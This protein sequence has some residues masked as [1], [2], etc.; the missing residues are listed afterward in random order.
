M[1]LA[2]AAGIGAHDGDRLGNALDLFHLGFDFTNLDAVA[3]DLDLAVGAAKDIE[4]P[5]GAPTRQIA[6]A[7]HATAMERVVDEFLGR[8]IRPLPIPK[9][10]AA[11]PDPELPDLADADRLHC[12]I[13]NIEPGI[14][15]RSSDRD[16]CGILLART[17]RGPD[18]GLGRSIHV[19][20]GCRG[21]F[22]EIGH[23]A[24]GHDLAADHQVFHLA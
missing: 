13:Q 9:R 17:G 2:N 20:N 23:Q 8:Q 4:C 21:G 19:F 3:T 7:E 14:R 5:V 12:V 22:A 24:C 11:A 18:R 10:D 1:D 6:G 15:D 16:D